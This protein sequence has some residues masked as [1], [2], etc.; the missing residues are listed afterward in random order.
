MGKADDEEMMAMM[1]AMGM[2]VSFGGSSNSLK[3]KNQQ[4]R[5]ANAKAAEGE[6]G[7]AKFEASRRQVPLVEQP[8]TSSSTY[9]TSY[10]TSSSTS[11]ALSL[12]VSLAVSSNKQQPAKGEGEGKEASELAFTSKVDEDE[13]DHDKEDFGPQV[14]P[15][16]L[17]NKDDRDEEEGDNL[18]DYSDNLPITHEILLKDHSKVQHL[19]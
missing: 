19:V 11:S 16:S 3:S 9:S 12:A 13:D 8:S 14:P 7:S 15:S 10:S 4:Q 2:P 18:V 17:S 6:V 1:L 5:Q